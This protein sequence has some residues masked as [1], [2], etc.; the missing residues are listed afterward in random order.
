MSRGA[1]KV[2]VRV[3]CLTHGM[4]AEA[5]VEFTTESGFRERVVQRLPAP[6][7]SACALS[8]LW[9]NP[10]P[11][12]PRDAI[13]QARPGFWWGLKMLFVW[14]WRLGYWDWD[15]FRVAAGW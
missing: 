1:V 5:R 15:A 14:R 3:Y 9:D 12:S 11:M 10:H 6:H 7:T 8:V 2:P 13:R 4:K